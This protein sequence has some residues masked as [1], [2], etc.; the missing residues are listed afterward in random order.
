MI[1][2]LIDILN[3]LVGVKEKKGGLWRQ[4]MDEKNH[5][6]DFEKFCPKQRCFIWNGL[7]VCQFCGER[8]KKLSHFQAIIISIAVKILRR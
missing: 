2:D 8:H 3:D 5:W 1:D 6:N 4:D 7:E